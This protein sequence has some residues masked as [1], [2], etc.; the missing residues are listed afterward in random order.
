MEKNTLG[1]T[2]KFSS[3]ALFRLSID[4]GEDEQVRMAARIDLEIYVYRLVQSHIHD[5]WLE[6]KRVFQ[7]T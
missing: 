5:M 7:I 4:G 1:T 3:S 6:K 2:F